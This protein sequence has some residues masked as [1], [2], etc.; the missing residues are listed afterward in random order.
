ML[1]T[2]VFCF[3]TWK[4]ASRH[5]RMHFFNISTSKSGLRPSV[6]YAFDFHMCFAPQRR[7]FFPHLNFQECSDF[8][9]FFA[10]GLRKV[11]APQRRAI[12][13][14]LFD[15][16]A[17]HLPAFV[18]LIFSLLPISSPLTL[19]TSAVRSICPYCRKMSDI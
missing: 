9:V 15:Q 17:P 7:A 2:S 3:L 13:N 19:P 16:M 4:F 12:L 14:F 6:L 1:R 18:F 5:D 10:F 11:F 8:E